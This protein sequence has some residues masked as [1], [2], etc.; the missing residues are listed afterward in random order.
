MT[1]AEL[2]ANIILSAFT[3]V[4][5]IFGWQHERADVQKIID[6]C[7]DEHATT[8]A[9]VDFSGSA[10]LR[11]QVCVA[12]CVYVDVEITLG[13]S[14]RAGSGLDAKVR[15]ASGGG[16][17]ASALAEASLH[18]E[19]V[20]KLAQAQAALVHLSSRMTPKE[21]VDAC[22]ELEGRSRA[23]NEVIVNGLGLG[24]AS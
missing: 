19:W 13:R 4:L 16:D 21:C 1:P 7:D 10:Q 24:E 14:W 17:V 9:V 3:Q 11:R 8:L 23:I 12:N 18:M 6:T 15:W 2:N 22:R 5:R 20:Q